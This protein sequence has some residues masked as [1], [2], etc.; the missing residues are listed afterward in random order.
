MKNYR[1]EIFVRKEDMDVKKKRLSTI[2]IIKLKKN[3]NLPEFK[4]NNVGEISLESR[5]F[6]EGILVLLN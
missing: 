2:K 3:M 1:N 6:D 4:F 5:Q